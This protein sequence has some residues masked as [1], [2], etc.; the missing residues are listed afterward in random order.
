MSSPASIP[1]LYRHF[2]SVG[3][4]CRYSEDWPR[5]R[6]ALTH[7]LRDT[8]A[9]CV[10]HYRRPPLVSEFEWWRDHQLELARAQGNDTL[11]LPSP[12]PFR[13]R[14]GTWEEA[15]LHCGYTPD[16]VAERNERT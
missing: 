4:V 9:V 8:L 11:H 5:A 13:R 1:R 7:A 6:E 12:T 15:L 16:Q 14:W 10:T 3:K 2:G